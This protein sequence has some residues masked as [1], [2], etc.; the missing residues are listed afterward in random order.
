MAR[1]PGIPPRSKDRLVRWLPAD[2]VTTPGGVRDG[3][4][5][6]PVVHAQLTGWR[7]SPLSYTSS[8]H[9]NRK[10][11]AVSDL[12]F[13]I[14]DGIATALLNRPDK[15]N[16]FSEEMLGGLERALRQ[17]QDDAAVRVF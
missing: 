5:S 2:H 12:E 11:F 1:P 6:C 10:D 13:S 17:A 14:K 16:A 7:P 8:V 4:P 15:K 3:P 9:L